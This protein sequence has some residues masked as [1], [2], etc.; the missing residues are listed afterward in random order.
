[1]KCLS[2]VVWSEGMHLTPQHFQ[3]QSRYFEDL[4]W[5]LNG[6]LHNHPWGLLSFGLDTDLIR[7]G[8]A[9]LSFGS[10]IFPD[11]LIFDIP[12]SDLRPQ[13][14][15][16]HEI[17]TPIDSDMI[18]HIAVPQR[19]DQQM[20]TDLSD[21]KRTRFGVVE[22]VVRDE[23]ISTEEYRITLSRKNLL[24]L[25]ASQIDKSLISI[26]IARVVRD[27]KGG[28]A[29]DPTFYPPLLRIGAVEDLLVRVQHMIEAI[30]AKILI[31]RS[32]QKRTGSFE[33]GSSALDV[34]SYW[35]LHSL[36]T[37]IPP[38]RN[39]LSARDG[40]PE[41]LYLALSSLAGSLC[42]FAL[43]ADP[44]EIPAYDHLQLNA[45]FSRLERLIYR[46][47]E[48]VVPSNTVTLNFT[49]TEPAIFTAPVLDERSFRRSRWILGIR[50]NLSESTLIRQVPSSLKICSAEGVVK[51][52]QRALP[53]LELSH[54]PVPPSAI[55]AQ[56]DMHYFSIASAGPCWQHI[57]AT[58]Q[59]GVY[60]PN[61]LGAAVFEVTIITEA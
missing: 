61:E 49:Q 22:K 34:A 27:G 35:F 48:V 7:N 37:A 13:P 38:L 11:G 5:F 28:F 15:N 42:T 52:V 51:L 12:D 41:E 36:C 29:I 39:Q 16:L 1:M 32:G 3:L 24:L 21:T 10:G 55:S 56:A 30:E 50:S 57:L 20:T 47:L 40:H 59:V 25:G 53:G 9:V 23:T 17:F 54:V 8:S 6:Q 46:N 26:P 31:T 18:L 45:V 60:L 44:S 43:D 19:V 58:R 2:R 4:L 33:I 14:L